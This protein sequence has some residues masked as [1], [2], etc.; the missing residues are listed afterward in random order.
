MDF[1]AFQQKLSQKPDAPA[2][3]PLTVAQFTAQVERILKQGLPGSVAVR[4]EV[5]NL[6]LHA[7]SGHLYFT[8][9]DTSACV[10]CVMYRSDAE[11][12]RFKVE[13]GMDLVATGRVGVF[14]ARGRYQL[15]I[16]RLD[17]V[18]RG[19]LE[20]ALQQLREK[21][22]REGLFEPARKKPIP[23]YPTRIAIVTSLQTAALQ[24]MLKVL[25]DFRHQRKL[26]YHV[27]VQGQGA[28]AQIAGALR[29]LSTRAADLGGIDVILLGRGGGSLE[30]L[31]PFNEEEVV[32]A[33]AA[34]KIPIV[35]GVGHEI[36]T[37]L[38]DLAADYHAHTPTEAARIITA[39]WRSVPERLGLLDLR[40]RREVR[41]RLLVQRQRIERAAAHELFRRPMDLVNLRRQRLDD[42]QRA[43]V[44]AMEQRLARAGAR[45]AALALR[46]EQN[47]PALLIL[48][49]RQRLGQLFSRLQEHSP[50]HQVRLSRA[51]L[52]GMSQQLDRAARQA[53]SRRAT[54]LEA[55]GRHLRAIGPEQVLQRGYSITSRKKGGVI[56][57]AGEVKSGDRLVTRFADGSVE[58]TAQNP[59]QMELFE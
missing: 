22:Q 8:L 14:A 12:L 31:W 50:R 33:V 59:G 23:P 25:A 48:R 16:H 41:N 44:A 49:M 13:D 7:P 53:I 17:P 24:D 21:L 15:V 46:L 27:P 3:R 9:K 54:A 26:V 58:S 6:K 4:G 40:L 32:R 35:T 36:D 20:L 30:D 19:A 11:R 28:A 45:L 52:A 56:R 43:L 10:D 2:P 5:S 38:A 39:N 55:L 57:S 18:G 1:F 42:R 47:R 37:S 51:R 29:D 34:S